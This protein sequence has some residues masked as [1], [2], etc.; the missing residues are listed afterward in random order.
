VT[1]WNEKSLPQINKEDEDLIKDFGLELFE[2]MK[3]LETD[4]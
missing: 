3:S 2:W 1:D 4:L